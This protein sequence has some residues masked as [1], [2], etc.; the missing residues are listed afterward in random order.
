MIKLQLSTTDGKD[1]GVLDFPEHPREVSI[2]QYIDFQKVYEKYDAFAK[3]YVE[4]DAPT[5][6]DEIKIIKMRLDCVSAFCGRDLSKLPMGGFSDP[7]FIK[8][9]PTILILFSAIWQIMALYVAPENYNDYRFEYKGKQW[10]IP[11]S[12][13]DAITNQER[14]SQVETARAIESLD[15]WRL[16]ESVAKE[17]TTGGYY[18]KTLLNIISCFA[19][20]DDETFPDADDDIQRFISERVVYFKEVSM[21]IA[22]DVHNFFFG[23]SNPY[24]EMQDL[25]I[26][27]IHRNE[28][29]AVK[30]N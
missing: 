5:R 6:A 30:Q 2:Q 7:A 14:F 12:Y 22:L 9:R 16:Y 29:L 15:A 13:R 1:L 25:L 19:K 17:D 27:L 20:T 4:K 11:T 21:Q 28:S 8:S 24:T 3:E 23:T 10:V 18:F 26:S